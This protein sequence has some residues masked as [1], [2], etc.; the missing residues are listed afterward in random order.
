MTYR[1]LWQRLLPIYE[2]SE[3]QAVVRMMLEESFG[4]SF[5]DICCGAVEELE[6]K[7]AEHLEAMM[8]RLE[9]GEPVQYVLGHALFCGR[10]FHVEPGVLIPRPETEV[11][12]QWIEQDLALP[13]CALQPPVP[14]RILD[15]GTGSGCIAITLAL[16]TD[17][18]NVEAWDISPE[19]LLIARRNA[20]ALGA[21]INLQLRDIL[22][23]DEEQSDVFTADDG[24]LW[25]IIVSNPPYICDR[26]RK[27]MRANVLDYEPALALFV[28]DDDPLRFYRAIAHYAATHLS[29]GGAVYFETNPLYIDDIH[30]LLA[31]LGFVDIALRN[32]QFGRQ[33]FV[34][35]VK[36]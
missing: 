1:N 5:T 18:T 14:K 10:S 21:S 11:L 31:R 3:A 33:R 17:N 16:S 32:D 25:D 23:K 36:A 22:K 6:A 9:K 8:Q 28:P 7:D 29:E 4:M 19:A 34:K 30:Q 20:H 13:Y 12:C 2:A 24:Q 35:A 26:E 27:D 15:I